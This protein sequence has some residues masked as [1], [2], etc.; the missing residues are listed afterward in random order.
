MSNTSL[1]LVYSVVMPA[2]P[3]LPLFPCLLQT[4]TL[5]NA[6]MLPSKCN[7]GLVVSITAICAFS[8][9]N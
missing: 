8:H 3:H 2:S 5:V 4:A 1:R 9:V 6:L 7:D